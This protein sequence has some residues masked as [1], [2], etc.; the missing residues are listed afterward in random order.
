VTTLE[1]LTYMAS[2][3]SEMMVA[4]DVTVEMM[5]SSRVT[6]PLAVS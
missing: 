6:I 2:T 1:Q 4:V 5:G 3:L